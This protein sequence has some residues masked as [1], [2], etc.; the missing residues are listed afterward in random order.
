MSRIVAVGGGE[1]RDAKTEPIDK[2][3]CEMAGSDSP[4]ALFIPTASN[5]ASGYQ[6]GFDAYYGDHLGCRTRHLTLHD[7]DINVERISADI[8]WADLVYVG[9]GSVP[10]LLE[11]WREFDVGQLLCE[12]YRDGTVMS[13]LSAGAV[14][15]FPTGFI[16]ISD[17]GEYVPMDCLG[18]FDDIVFTPHATPTRREVFREYMQSSDEIGIALEDGCAIELTDGEFRILSVSGDETAYRYK[19]VDGTVRVSEIDEED[20]FR[21]IEELR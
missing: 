2:H 4:T 10:R 3:I 19:Q 8:D 7:R 6:D 13:G 9:G 18:W 16:D 17:T 5:D 15:W 21:D 11:R 1:I 20:E 14:C 12:A